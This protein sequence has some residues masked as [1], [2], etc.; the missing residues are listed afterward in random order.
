[1]IFLPCLD[2]SVSGH[3]GRGAPGARIHGIMPAPCAN[4]LMP[5]K[6]LARAP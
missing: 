5:V 6:A 2:L 3:A 4:P 1:M